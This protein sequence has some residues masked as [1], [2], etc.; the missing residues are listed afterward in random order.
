MLVNISIWARPVSLQ[1]IGGYH[2]LYLQYSGRQ[3]FR[4]V[5]RS[6]CIQVHIL[7]DRSAPILTE[8]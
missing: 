6:I 1:I 7:P 4:L 2:R 3:D 5:Q 8:V